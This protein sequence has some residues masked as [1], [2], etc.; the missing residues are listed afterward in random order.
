MDSVPSFVSSL[1]R[2]DLYLFRYLPH[3][4][5]GA[6]A[7]ITCIWL[8]IVSLI[9][10]RRFPKDQTLFLQVDGASD[11]I[12]QTMLRFAC[13]LCQKKI[14]KTV[15]GAA[16][17]MHFETDGTLNNL[18]GRPIH[19]LQVVISRLPVGHT[20]EDIDQK[21]SVISQVSITLAVCLPPSH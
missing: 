8:A 3:V 10:L 13:W 11:N 2:Q 4:S 21:F 6:N 14:C 18:C 19:P 17:R 1:G 15:C 7:V 16:R 9:K 5:G 20:H 12:N